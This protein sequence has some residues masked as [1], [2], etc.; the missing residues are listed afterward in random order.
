MAEQGAR[1]AACCLRASAADVECALS[2]R[3]LRAL[4][5]GAR[6]RTA[7]LLECKR[8]PW[9][10]GPHPR[11]RW[12]RF[13]MRH[14]S[15]VLSLLALVS[16]I[17]CGPNAADVEELKKGQK[18]IL[19]KLESLDKAVQQVKAAPAPAAARP[20]VDPN[21]VYTIPLGTSPVKGPKDAKVTI[22]KFSDYQCPF[23][24]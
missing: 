19:A 14:A 1:Q 12:R 18:D 21:K 9:Q 3:R 5:H 23:C 8:C 4:P 15:P 20:Q 6:S 22:V 7:R 11:S 17:G 13:V 2:R 24:S 16:M 10:H